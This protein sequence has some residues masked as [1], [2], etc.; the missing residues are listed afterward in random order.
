VVTRCIAPILI[1]HSLRSV[2]LFVLVF[3][4]TVLSPAQEE[5]TF[6]TQSNVV[7]VP[8]LVRSKS[9]SIIYGLKTDDFIVEDDGIPQT[10]HLDEAAET[11]PISLVVAVQVG[12]RA[13]FELPRMRGLRTMLDPVFQQ[14]GSKVA[15]LTFDSKV[16]LL[17]TFSGDDTT[18]ASDLGNLQPGDRGAAVL[19]AISDA[20]KLLDGVPQNR[21]RVLLLISET[22]DHGSQSVTIGDVIEAIGNS[23]TVVYALAFSPSKS[24]VL[25]TLRGNNNWDLHPEQTEMHPKPD[26]LA[27][28]VL[29]A[30]AMRKNA[31]KA[32][33]VQSGG[34]YEMFSSGKGFDAQMT[35]FSNHLHS[36]YLLSFQP[37]KPHRGLHSLNVKLNGPRD[38]TVLARTSYW[39]EEQR[40]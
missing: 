15:L 28:F 34:E 16:H 38:A 17:E 22:R 12:R 8:A 26:L 18:I 20:V 2:I 11:E 32:I 37:S 3:T 33:A 30:Q 21:K 40:R 5:P 19:D 27:P 29:A 4:F 9:G 1:Q 36:R 23:N 13:D 39:A 25:D 35:N 7:L 6:R 14:E 10:V 31:A 24:N